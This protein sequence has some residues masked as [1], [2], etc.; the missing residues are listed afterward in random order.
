ME[1]CASKHKLYAP[2]SFALHLIPD[3]NIH[4]SLRVPHHNFKFSYGMMRGYSPNQRGAKQFTE[5]Q[6]KEVS[7]VSSVTR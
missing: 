2:A 4:R 5:E 6:F 3:E 1:M 7:V